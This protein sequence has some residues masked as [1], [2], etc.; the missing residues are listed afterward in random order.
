M[1]TPQ[2]DIPPMTPTANPWAR[3]WQRLSA[4]SVRGFHTYANWLVSISWRRFVVLSV[5][6]V[7][8][9]VLCGVLQNIPPFNWSFIRTISHAGEDWLPDEPPAPPAASAPE[10]A[11]KP[12]VRIEPPDPGGKVELVTDEHISLGDYLPSLALLWIVASLIT[13]ISYQR[14][15]QAEA[16][17]AQAV[18]TAESE[19]LKRQVVEPAWR[20]CR[21]RWSRTFCSTPWPASTI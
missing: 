13:K 15:I 17:A 7:L 2:P 21:R 16:Q 20:P 3:R 10:R 1:V 9:L 19:S 12:S 4:A 14:Q 18:A 6:S 11:S 5:L 8:L